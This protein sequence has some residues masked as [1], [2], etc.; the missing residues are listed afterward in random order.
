MEWNG[1]DSIGLE[2]NGIFDKVQFVHFSYKLQLIVLA[3]ALTLT[4][5]F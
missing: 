3:L 2:W 1:L 4:L 5:A